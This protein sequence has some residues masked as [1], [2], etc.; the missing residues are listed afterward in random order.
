MSSVDTPTTLA[1]RAWYFAVASANWCASIEQSSENASGKKYS[2]TG[3]LASDSCSEKVNT[4]PPSA[5]GMLKFG[6]RSPT[7]SAAHARRPA[8]QG[9]AQRQPQSLHADLLIAGRERTILPE[10]PPVAHTKD[11]ADWIR[12]RNANPIQKPSS[13]SSAARISARALASVSRHS[14]SGTESATTPAAA[15]TYSVWFCT[16]PVRMAIATSMSPA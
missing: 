14:I 16:M 13:T 3:P 1:P 11:F 8:R 2:T 4:W 9:Q 7:S 10:R 12:D 15:C 6:A 5:A